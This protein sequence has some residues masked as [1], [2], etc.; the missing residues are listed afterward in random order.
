M[1]RRRLAWRFLLLALIVILAMGFY[2]GATHRE[3]RPGDGGSPAA[4]DP[5]G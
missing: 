1:N 2:L 5:R 4:A 3:P